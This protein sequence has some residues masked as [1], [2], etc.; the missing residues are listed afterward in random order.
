MN[1]PRIHAPAKIDR[2]TDGSI[3]AVTPLCF[4]PL[5]S[6]IPLNNAMLRAR[7]TA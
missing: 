2:N 6:I 7:K 3:I 5:R 4:I 1:S